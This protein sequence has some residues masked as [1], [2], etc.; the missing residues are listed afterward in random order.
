MKRRITAYFVLALFCLLC[1]INVS[2]DSIQYYD[3]NPMVPMFE[4]IVDAEVSGGGASYKND[5]LESKTYRYRGTSNDSAES[6]I[7]KYV[8]YLEDHGFKIVISYGC[9]Y[10][11]YNN[12]Q[13]QLE[14][15]TTYDSRIDLT[16]MGSES[17][18]AYKP[19]KIDVFSGISFKFTGLNGFGIAELDDSDCSDEIHKHFNYEIFFD[20]DTRIP[21]V[22]EESMLCNGVSVTVK[23][24]PIDSFLTDEGFE[25]ESYTK[26]FS[27]HGLPEIL[28]LTDFSEDR[29]WL[30]I[31]D[32][33][34]KHW[35]C[36]D[37][38][39]K[40]LFKFTEAE[41]AIKS[42]GLFSNGY[43]HIVKENGSVAVID[44]EGKLTWDGGN[45]TKVLSYGD[46][47]TLTEF[48]HT[49][50]DETYSEYV[51]YDPFGNELM[52]KIIA[53]EDGVKL[54][55]QVRN[56]VYCGS[57]VFRAGLSD[58]GLGFEY[59]VIFISCK[60]GSFIITVA[61]QNA[62]YMNAGIGF[63]KFH[64]PNALD[65]YSGASARSLI[66][67]DST[68]DDLRLYSVPTTGIPDGVSFYGNEC[69]DGTDIL[70]IDSA[71][72]GGIDN[73]AI[74]NVQKHKWF[75]MDK[76]YA[77]KIKEKE[78]VTFHDGI[79]T[80]SMIGSDR[81]K[82]VM[83][84]DNE[85]H[86]IMEPIRYDEYI[87][88]TNGRLSVNGMLYDSNGKRVDGPY[89]D[90]PFSDDVT[91]ND[92][93]NI[94]YDL[95]DNPLF[96]RYDIDNTP[97]V[98][99]TDNISGSKH[100]EAEI[101]QLYQ[102]GGH[103][104]RS[105]VIVRDFPQKNYK[106]T[107][108]SKANPEG[109][110]NNSNASGSLQSPESEWKVS[111][112]VCVANVIGDVVNVRK[113]ASMDAEVLTRVRMGETVN[114]LQIYTDEY[115]A[116]AKVTIESKHITGWIV[117]NYLDLNGDFASEATG[118]NETG[119]NIAT[120]TGDLVNLRL[121]PSTTSERVDLLSY[122]TEVEVL[123]VKQVDTQKWAHVNVI[124]KSITGWIVVRYLDMSEIAFK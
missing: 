74:Y 11:C 63:V 52:R 92:T 95:E 23:A 42:V 17:K 80:A 91:R 8:N 16:L 65:A 50:F 3:E 53:D 2:A 73:V 1:A 78:G 15:C 48:I 66:I 88:F 38:S 13:K 106:A 31:K 51:L 40:G 114:V 39:G 26:S 82:Y 70:F 55:G 94:F 89:L 7:E 60:D 22:A 46:G 101:L 19:I 30:V 86:P 69:T 124:G 14:V 104:L 61:N 90:H 64:Y 58:I 59:P 45:P 41:Y 107:N 108:I 77:T 83:I 111:D 87:P 24:T 34:G 119:S 110:L 37:K 32:D 54:S 12:G 29:A 18:E 85:L 75:F 27:V 103:R 47:Y 25:V 28:E 5:V 116:W 100:V 21:Y 20:K 102:S 4:S 79:V 62:D 117:T 35:I 44:K 115:V 76:K 72:G 105:S 98:I 67:I 33:E 57:G 120:V 121:W 96:Y 81:K 10:S 6:L 9:L 118:A 56:V 36:I 109:E 113:E 43:A 71:F 99:S 93:W 84:F 122:G 97:K 49:G 123:E 68:Q 112:M